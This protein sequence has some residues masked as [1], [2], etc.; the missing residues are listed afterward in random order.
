MEKTSAAETIRNWTILIVVVMTYSNYAYSQGG[1]L[2]SCELD[3]G[4]PDN[5]IYINEAEKYVIYNA[6][7]GK[8]H[9]RQRVFEDEPGSRSTID[10][11]MDI[12]LN[13]DTLI[14]ANSNS[15]SFVFI[16]TTLT[17][18]YAFTLPVGTADGRWLAFGNFHQGRCSVNPFSKADE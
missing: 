1:V 2:L 7:L 3:G 14:L 17:F 6:Q 11:G 12:T 4:Y 10:V 15:E 5:Q 18:A 9:E 8:N 16:K 13:N